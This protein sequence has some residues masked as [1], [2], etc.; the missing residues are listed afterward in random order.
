MKSDLDRHMEA[1]KIDAL[2]VRGSA[3]HNPAMQYFTGPIHTTRGF[4]LKVAGKDPVLFHRDM[5][6]DEAVRSGLETES[7]EARGL[8][9]IFE[10]TQG[11]ENRTDAILLEKIFQEYGVKGRVSVY[12]RVEV[13]PAYGTLEHLSELHPD[14]EIIGE[15]AVKSVLMQTRRTKD[16][17]EIERIRRMGE[18]TIAVVNDVR[19]FLTSHAVRD[20]FLVD[21]SGEKLTVGTVKRKIDLW[22]ALRGAENPE[23]TIFAIGYDAAV[24]HSAGTDTDP[25]P[26]GKTIV[27][28]IFPCE[29]GGGY[30]HDFTR[31][32]CLG[33][34]PDEV[35]SIYQDVLELFEWSKNSIVPDQFTRE[36]QRGVCQQFE[37]RGHTTIC[38]DPN[39]QSGYVHS[40]A[41]GLGLDIHEP[42]IYRHYEHNSDRV[43]V[44]SV[45]TIEPGLYYPEQEIGVRLED[46]VWLRPDGELETLVEFPLDLVVPLPG[47]TGT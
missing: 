34:A 17:D 8:S 27:F 46:T 1:A 5:E 40:L 35:L 26:I 3:Q 2:L 37:A 23:Q 11:D 13:G 6:R 10:Q 43:E 38:S 30:F 7:F 21:S 24:P 39:T 33:Y 12:G 14:I 44:N 20:G 15:D 45:F 47:V 42:P 9:E 31:S 22:L 4:L 32:W 29:V 19:N 28:D 36:V 16:T 18:I 41:H 25:I